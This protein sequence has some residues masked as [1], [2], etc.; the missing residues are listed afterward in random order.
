M[1]ALRR[2]M[3]AITLTAAISPS[4]RLAEDEITVRA[5]D[6]DQRQDTRSV[7]QMLEETKVERTR[8]IRCLIPAW[9]PKL[10]DAERANF[11]AASWTEFGSKG[12]R[13]SSRYRYGLRS[14]RSDRSPQGHPAAS[15][16]TSLAVICS[17][18]A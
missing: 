7:T 8:P 10:E 4:N 15:R 14:P 5:S 17:A 2:R 16:K 3:L 1:L 11:A 9:R 12:F 18:M 13:G 6:H